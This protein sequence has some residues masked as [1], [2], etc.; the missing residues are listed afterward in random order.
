M[1]IAEIAVGLPV[2]ACDRMGT[3][4][5]EVADAIIREFAG[6]WLGGRLKNGMAEQLVDRICGAGGEEFSLGV[7][8]A[9]LGGAGDEERARRGER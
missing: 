4:A 7:R 8:P 1:L 9:V 2:F 5:Q 3:L 6:R